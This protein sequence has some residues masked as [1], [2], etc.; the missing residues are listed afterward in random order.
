MVC[1]TVSLSMLIASPTTS[2]SQVISLLTSLLEG[3]SVGGGDRSDPR[4]RARV[5]DQL[6]LGFSDRLGCFRP[7]SECRRGQDDARQTEPERPP[8]LHRILLC[9]DPTRVAHRLAP[10]ASEPSF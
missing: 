10:G 2:W 1:L 5:D 8:C 6:L 9:Q 3:A 7:A 4:R